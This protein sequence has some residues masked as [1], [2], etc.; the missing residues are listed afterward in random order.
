MNDENKKLY[1]PFNLK[2]KNEIWEG[3]GKE[4]IPEFLIG[5]AITLVLSIIVSLI[6]HII[7]G[8]GI[9]IVGAFTTVAIITKQRLINLSVIDQM[10]IIIKHKTEQQ[11][12]DDFV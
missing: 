7:V 9:F 12:F 8:I 11:K 10:R 6:W 1:I 4:Q 5:I 3:F 2:I